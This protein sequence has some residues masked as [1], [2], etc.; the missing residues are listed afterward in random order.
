MLEESKTRYGNKGPPIDLH[1]FVALLQYNRRWTYTGSLTTA[2]FTEGILWNLLEHVIPLRQ[3]TLDMFLE[4]RKI[5]ERM[6]FNK[7]ANEQEKQET[8]A[9]LKIQSKNVKPWI[10]PKGETFFRVAACNRVVQD[11]ED[12]PVYHIDIE[13]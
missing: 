8:L 11:V 1:K 2:P 5:E 12:R 4:Y 3:T 13:P 6:N 7:F 10:S 9:K